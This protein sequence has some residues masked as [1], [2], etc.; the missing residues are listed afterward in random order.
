V[1]RW[2]EKA[3]LE[4][5]APTVTSQAA[6]Q[7]MEERRA[8]FPELWEL[9]EEE[10]AAELANPEAPKRTPKNRNSTQSVPGLV[11]GFLDDFWMFTAGTEEDVASARAVVMK[12]FERMGFIVSTSKLATEGTPDPEVVILGHDLDLHDGTRGMTHHK[13]V[14]IQDQVRGLGAEKWSRKKLEQLVGL[15]QSIR[16]DVNR[17]WNLHCRESCPLAVERICEARGPCR[18]CWKLHGLARREGHQEFHDQRAKLRDRVA[19]MSLNTRLALA[20]GRRNF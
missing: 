10:L 17:R 12:A 20:W 9:S 15:I 1:V 2:I 3:L 18:E 16:D 14:R 8:A 11:Q 6:R 5:W 19:S 13:R 7:W 4:E